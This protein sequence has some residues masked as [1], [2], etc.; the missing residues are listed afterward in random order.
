[1]TCSRR[2]IWF[3]SKYQ[4]MEHAWYLFY[5]FIYFNTQHKLTHVYSSDVFLNTCMV[6]KCFTPFYALNVW[7]I[8][9]FIIIF[10][11]HQFKFTLTI[12]HMQA[13]MDEFSPFIAGDSDLPWDH[14]IFELKKV[15]NC[16]Q[17]ILFILF[18]ALILLLT[19][20]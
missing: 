10:F 7:D 8:S 13:N 20:L 1:M 3:V 16:L 14:Y 12:L 9:L 6:L 17:L 2:R 5:Y 18:L 11:C 19:F 15:R 4:K